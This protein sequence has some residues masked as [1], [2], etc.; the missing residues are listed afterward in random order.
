MISKGMFAM[1]KKVEANSCG[2]R[3]EV[4]LEHLA[5]KEQLGENC[6]LFAKVTIPPGAS[7]GFHMHIGDSEIYHILSGSALYDDNGAV[8]RVGPGDVTYTRDGEGHGMDNTDGTEPVV[9]IALI[10]KSR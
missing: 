7:C 10:L 5:S 8:R 4:T 2:G 3:G 1:E 6:T 9:F